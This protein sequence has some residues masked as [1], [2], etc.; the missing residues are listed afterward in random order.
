[1]CCLQEERIEQ[2]STVSELAALITGFEMIAFLQFNFDPTKIDQTL[3]LAYAI[4]SALT[5]S[6]SL[7]ARC[8]LCMSAVIYAWTCMFRLV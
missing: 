2:L 3:Q 8:R 1:M 5:V 6:T 7:A 4:T